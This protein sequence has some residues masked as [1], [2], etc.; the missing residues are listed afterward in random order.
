MWRHAAL[1]VSHTLKHCR[2]TGG[3]GPLGP[4][5]NSCERSNVRVAGR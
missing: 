3:L 5:Q 2:P 1:F 4:D